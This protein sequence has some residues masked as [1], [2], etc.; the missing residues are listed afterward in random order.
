MS[1]TRNTKERDEYAKLRKMQKEDDVD[2]ARERKT[3]SQ[4]DLLKE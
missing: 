4:Q 3:E 1:G 2:A